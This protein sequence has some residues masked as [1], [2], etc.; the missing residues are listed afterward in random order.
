MA[1]VSYTHLDVY[2]RQPL[3]GFEHV[4]YVFYIQIF[5]LILIAVG[6]IAWVKKYH[7]SFYYP[8]FLK[9]SLVVFYNVLILPYSYLM[10]TSVFV[11][12]VLFFLYAN[13]DMNKEKNP[14]HA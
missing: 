10:Y 12:F 1:T 14:E 2:K 4:Q 7:H 9:L 8:A 5:L 13:H 3:I 6:M 11:S